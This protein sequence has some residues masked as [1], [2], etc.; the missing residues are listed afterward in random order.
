MSRSMTVT[1][2]RCVQSSIGFPQWPQFFS[3]SPSSAS[4][5][6][7]VVPRYFGRIRSA[8]LLGS[9]ADVFLPSSRPHSGFPP[10][11]CWPERS[12]PLYSFQC[13]RELSVKVLSYGRISVGREGYL[14][15]FSPW[16]AVRERCL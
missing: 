13:I 10:I 16:R 12:K 9:A 1:V 2:R 15:W 8:C 14:Y 5:R 6:D 3:V 11:P 4:L 7:G